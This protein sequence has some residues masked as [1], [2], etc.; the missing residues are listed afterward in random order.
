[1][2][3]VHLHVTRARRGHSRK[4][5]DTCMY[6]YLYISTS[7]DAGIRASRRPTYAVVTRPLH[8]NLFNG[9]DSR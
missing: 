1:M 2:T 4:V 7:V 9:R 6:R 8:G 5:P 3:N